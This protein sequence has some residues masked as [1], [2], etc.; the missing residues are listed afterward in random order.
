MS[1]TTTETVV[2]ATRRGTGLYGMAYASRLVRRGD[3]HYL[4]HD[5]WCGRGEVRGE[6]YR[7]RVYAVPAGMVAVLQ[8]V[9]EN[10]DEPQYD[11]Q[12][13]VGSKWTYFLGRGIVDLTESADGV[14][15]E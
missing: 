7:P 14:R 8:D 6:A 9:L 15:Y 13:W 3:R 5:E 2:I 10:G 12:P 11:D 4:V 1:E